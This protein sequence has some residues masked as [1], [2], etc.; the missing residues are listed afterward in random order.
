MTGVFLMPKPEALHKCYI[1]LYHRRESKVKKIEVREFD[2]ELNEIVNEL[3][4]CK[5]ECPVPNMI[6]QRLMRGEDLGL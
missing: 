2:L 6:E 3:Y 4:V 5:F 1:C